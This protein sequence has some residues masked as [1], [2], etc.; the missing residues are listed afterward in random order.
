MKTTIADLQDQ[1]ALAF[2]HIYALEQA[3]WFASSEEQLSNNAELDQLASVVK[4]INRDIES[5][6]IDL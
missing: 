1:K 4:C 5:L 3:F 6:S 2:E